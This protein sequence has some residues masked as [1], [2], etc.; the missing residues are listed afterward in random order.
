[1]KRDQIFCVS[2]ESPSLPVGSLRMA[3]HLAS[4]CAVSTISVPSRP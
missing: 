4:V 3:F 1:V 2:A